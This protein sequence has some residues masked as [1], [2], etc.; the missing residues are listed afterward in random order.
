MI[1]MLSGSAIGNMLQYYILIY[2]VVQYFN[3]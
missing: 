1:V 3:L 2:S